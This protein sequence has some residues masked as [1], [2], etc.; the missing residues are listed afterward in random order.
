VVS[1]FFKR[2]RHFS[3]DFLLHPIVKMGGIII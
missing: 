2:S 3:H 1:R